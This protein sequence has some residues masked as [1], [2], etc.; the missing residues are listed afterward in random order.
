[1]DF[2]C[3]CCGKREPVT[4]RRPQCPCGGLWDLEFT[5][6]KFDLNRVDRDQWSLFR[7]HPFLGLCG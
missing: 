6:P 2:I 1:M 5:P 4:T 7:Y 3:S